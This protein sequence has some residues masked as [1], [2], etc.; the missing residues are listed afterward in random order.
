[1]GSQTDL[2][3]EWSVDHD[4]PEPRLH[5]AEVLD[6]NDLDRLL[7]LLG[8]QA[9]ATQPFV[10]ELVTSTGARLGIGLGRSASVLAFKESDDPPYF[11]SVGRPDAPDDEDVGFYFQG[12]WTEFPASALVPVDRAREAARALLLATGHRPDVVSWEEV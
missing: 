3:V 5:K 9:A 2:S 7:D 12:H 4:S 1:M 8:E 10:A 11:M 6:S